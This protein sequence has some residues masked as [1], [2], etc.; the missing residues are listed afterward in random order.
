MSIS[1]ASGEEPEW[2]RGGAV[3]G[4][5]SSDD[6]DSLT[7]YPSLGPL[8]KPKESFG[9][10]IMPALPPTAIP[11]FLRSLRLPSSAPPSSRY[12]LPLLVST[13]LGRS[14]SWLPPIVHLALNDLPPSPSPPPPPQPFPLDDREKFPRRFALGLMKEALVK[15]AVLIG[16]PKAI[17]TLLELKDL[18]PPEDFPKNFVRE[19]LDQ[20]GETLDARKEAGRAGLGSVYQQQLDPIFQLM[21][22]SGLEDLRASSVPPFL[23]FFLFLLRLS[24]RS[25]TA[26]SRFVSR[27]STFP[28]RLPIRSR[29]LRHLPHPLHS[30]FSL[31]PLPRSLHPRPAPP[32]PPNPLNSHPS[33]YTTRDPLAPSRGDSAGVEEGGGGNVAEG[34]GERL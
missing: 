22:E 25:T 4:N 31:L 34:G 2:S 3:S 28:L 30:L 5:K 33:A 6:E 15:S 9:R 11:S 21:Q 16:V 19:K 13:T 12:L 14:H 1:D 32:I 17:E 23:F 29:H 8:E 10:R 24:L 18:V 7:S 20:P 27:F 26:D